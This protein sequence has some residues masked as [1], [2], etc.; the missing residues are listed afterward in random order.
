MARQWV[1]GSRHGISMHSN[2]HRLN[3]IVF[4]VHS[5][6]LPVTLFTTLTSANRSPTQRHTC[7]LRSLGQFEVL[8]NSLKQHWR[9]LMVQKLTF[10]FLATALVN[11]LAV[12]MPICTLPQNL[13]LRGIVLCDKTAHFRVAFSCPQYK[14]HLCNDHAV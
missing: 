12:S 6:C 13:R 8:P 9:R 1:S 7:G 10:N 3:A 4:V 11:I 14:V 2:C 5:L